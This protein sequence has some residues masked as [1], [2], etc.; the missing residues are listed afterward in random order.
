MVDPRGLSDTLSHFCPTAESLLDDRQPATIV[1]GD[2][3]LAGEDDASDVGLD[4]RHGL[5]PLLRPAMLMDWDAWSLWEQ[6]SV[7]LIDQAPHA[8]AALGQL[9]AAVERVRTWTP[10]D[11]PLT[12]RIEDGF[13][14]AGTAPASSQRQRPDTLVDEVLASVPDDWRPSPASLAGRPP[15]AHARRRFLIAHAFANWT[16]HLGMGLRSWLASLAAADRLIQTGLGLREADLL[17]RH[18]ADPMVLARRWS[19]REG[20]GPG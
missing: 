18:L 1:A 6:R 4:A 9:H 11:G 15:G 20:R 10:A 2:S 19:A 17:L 8:S 16:A 13:E 5:P 3:R 7:S 12:D 14:H